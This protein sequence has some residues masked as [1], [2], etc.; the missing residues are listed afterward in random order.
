MKGSEMKKDISNQSGATA[1]SGVKKK[2][3]MKGALILIAGNILIKIIGAFFKIPLTNLVG[4]TT[5]AYFNSAYSFYVMFFM[6]STS[7]LPVA[8]SRMVAR[9]RAVGNK[10]EIDRIFSV[11]FRMFFILGVL[12]TVAMA[13]FSGVFSRMSGM[14]EGYR[15]IIALSPTVFFICIISAYRGYFQGQQNMTPTAVSQTIEALGKLIIGLPAG[16]IAIKLGFSPS[17]VAAFVILGI[18]L[19]V[20]ASCASLMIAKKHAARLDYGA[21]PRQAVMSR[22]KIGTQLI[23]IAIPITIASSMASLVNVIDTALVVKRLTDIGYASE[24]AVAMYG[25]YTAKSITLYNLPPTLIYPF[26]ISLIPMV[27]ATL[28]ERNRQKLT[29]VINSTLRIVSM[30]SLPFAFGLC[31]LSRPALNLLYTNNAVIFVNALGQEVTS[32]DVAAPTLSVLGVG[33]FFVGM[34]SVTGAILQAHGYERLSIV[35]TLIGI[36][37]KFI[38]EIILLGIPDVGIFG[39]PISTLLCYLVMLSMNFL[40]LARFTGNR[41]PVSGVF[42]KPFIASAICTVSAMLLNNALS[43]FIHG[44]WVVLVS[45]AFAIVVYFAVVFLIKAIDKEDVLIMPKGEKILAV[46]TKLHL[47]S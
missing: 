34:I 11:S 8:I 46:L 36:T 26:S 18:T 42:L 3:F 25:A 17:Y 27:S 21:N 37:I 41:P 29:S 4:D 31:A 7:G 23:S 12:G 33:V 6:I 2:D 22:S 15:A 13:A 20:V 35:S 38:S 19:G 28:A 1:E 14:P 47:L 43:T 32:V 10:R 5:M 16:Y 30:I 45:I 24:A 39:A 40:F 9:C 44:R